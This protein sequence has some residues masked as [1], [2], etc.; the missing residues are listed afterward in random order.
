MSGLDVLLDGV[1]HL[2]LLVDQ[3]CQIL[4]D[5]V[6]VDDV[7]LELTNRPLAL[8]EVLDVL[9][10]LQQQLRLARA[11]AALLNVDLDPEEYKF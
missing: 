3:R 9:L 1:D 4:E 11:A 2:A 6:D 5:G 10:L 7:G 8:P